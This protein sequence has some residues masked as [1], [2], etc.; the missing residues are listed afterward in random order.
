M[1][2]AEPQMPVDWDD[3]AAW[4]Q[5][6]ARLFS[7]GEFT[8]RLADPGSFSF[9]RL[10]ELLDE[11]RESS[12]QV[13]WF[14]GCGLSPLPQLF[15]KAGFAVHA[16]DVSATAVDFQCK[17]EP[18]IDGMRLLARPPDEVAGGVLHAAVHDFR[19]PYLTD[20]FDVVFNVKSFQNLPDSSMLAA[21]RSHWLA[22]RAGCSAFFD[23]MNVQGD[24][25][26]QIEN[27]LVDAG[28]FVPL[29]KLNQWYRRELAATGIP[30][31]FVLGAPMIPVIDEYP[32]A[33]GSRQRERDSEVLQA[34]ASKYG[35]RRQAEWD[36]EQAVVDR[37][38]K[39]AHVIYT[40]G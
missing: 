37:S 3:H 20:E 21:A 17:S 9:D 19:A 4:D 27:I 28:F 15:A 11:L 40:T 39:T 14:P 35:E 1:A 7:A 29:H 31:A 12:L 10:P 8:D 30:H 33:H 24:R 34:I 32:H 38:R 16:T 25:R 13:V 22:L 5:Y 2:H 23:T 6:Y 26:D 18:A 36:A